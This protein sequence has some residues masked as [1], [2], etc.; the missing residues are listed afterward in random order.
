MNMLVC[1]SGS[2]SVKVRFFKNVN[3]QRTFK[4]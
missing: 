3:S 2:S 1:N 4:I